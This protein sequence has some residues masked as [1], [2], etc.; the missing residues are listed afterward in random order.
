MFDLQLLAL[1]ADLTRVSSFKFGA[2]SNGS[3]PLSGVS[4]AWHSASHHGNVPSAI[5]EFN[6]INTYRTDRMTYLLE[7]LKNTMEGGSSLL[8]KSVVMWGV[9]DGRP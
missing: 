9:G 2:Q 8:D 7:K 6:T 1:Q 4:K 3:F 5:L